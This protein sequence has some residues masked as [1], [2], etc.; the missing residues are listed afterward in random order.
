[1]SCPNDG[2]E[3]ASEQT[4]AEE[5]RKRLIATLIR[6]GVRVINP[7]H[8]Y[9]EETVR[10][11]PDVTLLPGTHLRGATLIEAGC[12]IGPDCWVQDSCVEADCVVRYSV[13]EGAR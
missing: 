11:A 12:T 1:M 2:I 3:G 7:E 9:V 6:S 5:Q 4:S 8:T 10:V 13:V